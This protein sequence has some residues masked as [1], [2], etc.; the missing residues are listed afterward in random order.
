MKGLSL[1]TRSNFTNVCS[2]SSRYTLPLPRFLV[3]SLV[4]WSI[5]HHII[6]T[7]FSWIYRRPQKKCNFGADCRKDA[8]IILSLLQNS[9]RGQPSFSLYMRLWATYTVTHPVKKVSCEN[10]KYWWFGPNSRMHML[11]SVEQ[12]LLTE[13]RYTQGSK[14]E[15]QSN[16][17]IQLGK[18]NNWN[19]SR[20]WASC[21]TINND[22]R[23]TGTKQ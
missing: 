11:R 5:G 14:P 21:P 22:T 1:S 23:K 13:P 9:A 19:Q 15:C 3:F 6:M 20:L 8:Q 16:K 17:Q 2:F 4:C 18:G 12:R 10:H 7:Q